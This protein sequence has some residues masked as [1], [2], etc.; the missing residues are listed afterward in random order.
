MKCVDTTIRRDY[1]DDSPYTGPRVLLGNASTTPSRSWGTDAYRSTGACKLRSPQYTQPDSST[2]TVFEPAGTEEVC[3][4]LCNL[5]ANCRAYEYRAAIAQIPGARLGGT[6]T[7]LSGSPWFA[8]SRCELHAADVV[9]E[10]S[11]NGNLDASSNPFKFY[12]CLLKIAHPSY[13]PAE[14]VNAVHTAGS[15]RRA[16]TAAG[17]VS[18]RVASRRHRLPTPKTVALRSGTRTSRPFLERVRAPCCRARATRARS[19]STRIDKDERGD[20]ATGRYVSLRIF[21]PPQAPAPR[22]D[23]RLRRRGRVGTAALWDAPT[24]TMRTSP[25]PPTRRPS[26]DGYRMM[27]PRSMLRTMRPNWYVALARSPPRIPMAANPSPVPRTVATPP[28]AD[29]SGWWHALEVHHSPDDGWLYARRAPPGAHGV[30][31]AGSL[32]LA[33]ALAEARETEVP[34]AY[35]GQAVTMDAMCAWL[36]STLGCHRGDHWSL[37]YNRQI[38]LLADEPAVTDDRRRLGDA[39]ALGPSSSP[40]STSWSR[41]RCAAPRAPRTNW[42]VDGTICASCDPT[43]R[44]GRGDYERALAARRGQ[45]WWWWHPQEPLGARLRLFPCVPRRSCRRGGRRHGR[46]D[47]HAAFLTSRSH[48]RVQRA[49]VCWCRRRLSE[50][51][52]QWARGPAAHAPRGNQAAHRAAAPAAPM[53]APSARGLQRQ[54]AATRGARGRAN[55]HDGHRVLDAS[56]N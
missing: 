21:H 9:P 31:A 54:R 40:W 15:M 45:D 4:N 52:R 29:R 5:D 56:S 20:D 17:S 13:V 47:G 14:T 24:T 53:D 43:L 2:I 25:S 18:A 19:T 34:V 37:L 41:T 1:G 16:S 10:A 48:R 35:H 7:L 26:C 51:R 12:V 28:L 6:S 50:R 55:D 3:R 38:G 36:S 32:G 23:A 42:G 33:V 30:S 11:G 49:P 46:R 44:G 22:L 27:S 8:N 39:A